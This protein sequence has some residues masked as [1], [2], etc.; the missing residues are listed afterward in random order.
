MLLDGLDEV[1]DLNSR[2]HLVNRL[3]DFYARHA[4]AGNNPKAGNKFVIT[5]RIVGYREAP[6]IARGLTECAL[7]DFTGEEIDA[8]VGKWTI[9]L[10][11]QASGDTS[12]A[13]NDAQRERRERLDAV[14]RNPGVRHLAANPLLLTILALM[15]RQGVRLPER[16]VELYD[17]YVEVLL[18]TWNRARSLDRPGTHDVDVVG[19]LRILAPLALWMHETT[20][21]V[22]LVKRP[23]LLQELERIYK[24]RGEQDPEASSRQ[25]LD[26]VHERAGLL[27]ERGR[28]E[29]GF[30]H[31]TFEE[32]LA[33]VGVGQLGQRDLEPVI[34]YLSGC[35]GKPAW[36]EVALLTIG[37]VGLVQRRDEAAGAVVEALTASTTGEPGAAAVLA[38][39]AVADAGPGVVP[40]GSRERLSLASWR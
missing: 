17:K 21:G 19:T 23:A 30:I 22:G 7:V 9:A 37:Y 3:H 6:L 26:D 31:L 2:Y 11:Q 15:K 27:L 29:Y 12:L 4:K 25:F 1:K 13:R 18:S 14:E 36:R 34:E 28:G 35:V 38:G 40:A 33:A 10:E 24:K 20:P 16:R 8:F 39:E 5:T 32:Y